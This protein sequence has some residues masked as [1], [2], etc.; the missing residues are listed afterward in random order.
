VAK[1]SKGTTDAA[2]AGKPQPR[3]RAAVEKEQGLGPEPENKVTF[4][5]G[6]DVT[7]AVEGPWAAIAR[8]CQAAGMGPEEA[9]E[10]IQA[11]IDG[12]AGP[13]GPP[14]PQYDPNAPPAGAENQQI[15][16]RVIPTMRFLDLLRHHIRVVNKIAKGGMNMEARDLLLD[17]V[18]R[19]CQLVCKTTPPEEWCVYGAGLLPTRPRE[20]VFGLPRDAVE[21]GRQR[22][23]ANR[24]G[25][26]RRGRPPAPGT[27]EW[28]APMAF[29]QYGRP[30]R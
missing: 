12:E 19:W 3:A 9:L 22:R 24:T 23:I 4:D 11:I 25:G 28:Q 6:E 15:E 18:R 17:E 10:Y 14:G 2:P 20:E 7:P 5:E 13:A 16:V 21:I 27:P 8:R 1:T 26:P 30:L 29:D